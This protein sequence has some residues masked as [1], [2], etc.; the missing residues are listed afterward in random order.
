MSSPIQVMLDVVARAFGVQNLTQVTTETKKLGKASQETSADF[1]DLAG[2]FTSIVVAQHLRGGIAGLIKPAADMELAMKQ[3]SITSGATSSDLEKMENAARKAAETVPYGPLEATTNLNVLRR[4]LGNTDD[5]IDV[6]GTSMSVAM[7]TFDKISTEKAA[8]MLAA[9]GRSFGMTSEEIK[10]GASEIFALTKVMGTEMTDFSDVMGSLGVAAIRG[11]QSFEEMVQAFALARNIMPSSA[12]A[13]TQLMRAM[14][15]LSAPKTRTALGQL[16]I[17]I[18]DLTT[19][20]IL[21]AS[22]IFLQ[23]T[24]SMNQ[25]L[26]ATRDA[27][28]EAFGERST[29]VILAI[30]A[31]LQKSVRTTT[32]E[33]LKGAEAYAYM[34]RT[35]HEGRSSLED[36]QSIY[37]SS[38]QAALTRTAQAWENLKIALG[39]SLLGAVSAIANALGGLMNVLRYITTIPGV[40]QLISS[41]VRLTSI[42]TGFFALNFV[43]FGVKKVLA[44]VLLQFLA[45]RKLA[46]SAGVGISSFASKLVLLKNQAKAAGGGL[47]YL[48][49]ATSG[50]KYGI[51]TLLSSTGIGLLIAWLPEIIDGVKGLST[52]LVKSAQSGGFL[53]WAT[54]NIKT[55]LEG[56][57]DSIGKLMGINNAGKLGME[58]AVR[59]FK[60]LTGISSV[61]ER[62]TKGLIKVMHK[63]IDLNK[64]MQDA[65]KVAYDYMHLGSKEME[66]VVKKLQGIGK[67][68]PKP[69]DF[70]VLETAVKKAEASGK[71]PEMVSAMRSSLEMAKDLATKAR[72]NPKGISPDE[73]AHLA[74]EVSKITAGT[75]R[76]NAI[77]GNYGEDFMK[78]IRST[79]GAAMQPFASEAQDSAYFNLAMGG[80]RALNETNAPIPGWSAPM[81][82]MNVDPRVIM[83]PQLRAIAQNKNF[84]STGFDVTTAT[85][86]SRGAIDTAAGMMPEEQAAYSG[87]FNPKLLEQSMAG[88]FAQVGRSMLESLNDIR[89]ALRGT[90]NVKKDG[91]DPLMTPTQSFTANRL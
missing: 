12:Q 82:G 61:E 22:K 50:L 8:G 32:G 55:Q 51:K 33:T 2:A 57:G 11:G 58:G 87:P 77:G 76:L 62:A 43:L 1:K 27:L 20:G 69:I 39:K 74:G 6:L 5:A 31:Q 16:G 86:Q 29:K 38:A 88:P 36:A 54:S 14:G 40:S 91:D 41:L 63:Q 65:A 89:S 81:G 9:M 35:M 68:D 64:S 23:V 26:F 13:A 56:M 37:S 7:S 46:K 90:L 25:N 66:E 15:E 34:S 49:F 60:I 70:K 45:S 42:A 79:H 47:K 71:K 73:M 75:I 44:A 18:K 21:P 85:D 30:L 72:S 78:K 17:E 59:Y 52:W 3:L 48:T 84:R 80:G 10:V 67:Y 83:N 19:G 4:A 24:E 28:K 53:A